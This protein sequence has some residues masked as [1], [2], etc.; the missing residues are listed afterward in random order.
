MI[1]S[2]VRHLSAG[3][4]GWVLYSSGFLPVG[5]FQE[6]VLVVQWFTAVVYRLLF[7]TR[8]NLMRRNVVLR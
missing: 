2:V 3:R 8:Q 7:N 4:L 5:V 6:T 1:L